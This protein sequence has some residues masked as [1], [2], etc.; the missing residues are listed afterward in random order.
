MRFPFLFLIF[1]IVP[2]LEIAA[3]VLVGSRIG[4]LATLGMVLFTAVVGSVLLRVQGFG[5]LRRIQ[6]ETDAGRVPGRE[7][8]HGGMILLAGFLLLLPGFV[9]DAVGFL[10]F[11]PAFRD[12]MWRALAKRVLVKVDLAGM[13]YRRDP[14]T[15]DLEED[16]FSRTREGTGDADETSPWRRI[17]RDR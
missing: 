17:D 2:L 16:E 8:V 10:L 3:F 4:V 13:R 6:A 12:W 5:L 15:I 7:L 1:L 14:R 9:T 11:V